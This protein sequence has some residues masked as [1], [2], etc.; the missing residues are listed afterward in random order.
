MKRR[1]FISCILLILSLLLT[2]CNFGEDTPSLEYD[3]ASSPHT[4]DPQHA[5]T[6][7]ELTVVYSIFEGLFVLDEN[8]EPIYA[9]CEDME[10]SEGGTL[11]RF[12]LRDD[13]YWQDGEA[14]TAHDFAFALERLFVGGGASPYSE[15]FMAIENAPQIV[16]GEKNIDSLGVSVNGEGELV[17]SLS[18]PMDELPK[19]L[20]TSP[21]MPCREDFFDEQWGKYG[22]VGGE[23]IG[24]GVF[25]LSGWTENGITLTPS[26]AHREPASVELFLNA[27]ISESYSRFED[28][29]TQLFFTKYYADA[30]YS[31]QNHVNW[32]LLFNP[33]ASPYDNADVR[34]SVMAT[35]L[36]GIT[37]PDGWTQAEGVFPDN[38]LINSS[39]LYRSGV[40]HPTLPE[41]YQNP[42]E[43]FYS[44]LEASELLTLPQ[45][46]LIYPSGDVVDSV[47]T[48]IQAT[49]AS[50]LSLHV[51][52]GEVAEDNL[53]SVIKSGMY[54]IALLPLDIPLLE[55]QLLFLQE[56]TEGVMQLEEAPNEQ[57]SLDATTESAVDT[58]VADN[59]TA[60]TTTEN[61]SAQYAFEV[62]QR[63]LDS[64][65]VYPLF[66][67][68]T[69][70]L[71][72]DGYDG[73][74]YVAF[75]G[76]PD[77]SGVHTA[78]ED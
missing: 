14:V 21:A 29:E 16:N 40:G 57:A 33:E 66:S 46:T 53:E 24:N 54:S 27:G 49:L 4:L 55:E 61:I 8:E 15:R 78:Q 28:G 13:I 74:R 65:V 43:S 76:V 17:I 30:D 47:V 3:M 22:T 26:Q 32:V 51:G 31:G 25:N 6:T 77:F 64:A 20:A 39:E 35:I 44:A 45:S 58:V 18:E 34:N 68:P 23:I 48:S 11:Y 63:L 70:F 9:A 42:S 5:V 75:L 72:A 36:D 71:T 37:V 62:E 52:L 50:E 56:V 10:I 12:T 60:Q 67:S 69:Y 41:L 73:G 1:G 59:P 38:S 7:D 2:S 19:L